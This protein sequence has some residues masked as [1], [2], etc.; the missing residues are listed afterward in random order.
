MKEQI[1]KEYFVRYEVGDI[2]YHIITGDKGVVVGHYV[3]RRDV[4]YKVSF[5]PDFQQYLYAVEISDKKPL[6]E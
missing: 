4:M 3:D 5:T 1:K 2:I 6:T